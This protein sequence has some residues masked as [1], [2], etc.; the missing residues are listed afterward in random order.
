MCLVGEWE[1][2]GAERVGRELLAVVPHVAVDAVL[3]RVWADVRGLREAEIAEAVLARAQEVE[4]GPV[5]AGIAGTPVAAYASAMGAGSGHVIRVAVGQDR[6]Y[7]APLGLEVLEPDAKLAELLEGVGVER[8]GDLASLE[9]ESVE[10]RFGAES[11]LVWR[12]SRG[13]DARALFRAGSREQHQ[14]SLD[15]IDYVVTDPERLVF[16]ANAL[17]GGICESLRT[18]GLHARRLELT[19]PLA[20]GEV[21]RRTLTASRPTASRTAWLRLV[22]AVLERLTVAD[23]VAGVRIALLSSEAAASVQGDLFDAGFATASAVEAA[24]ARMIETHGPVIVRPETNA[25]PLVERRTSFVEVET[26]DCVLNEPSLEE[27]GQANQNLFAANSRASALDGLTLQILP[28]PRPV[29]VET[30]QRRDHAIPVRYHDVEWN[31]LTTV[32][33]P[34]RI[35]GGQWETPYARAYYRGLSSDGR[36]VWLYHDVQAETWY[37]HGW[38]D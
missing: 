29:L 27:R 19:L 22:R 14:A 4:S 35:S 36:L 2:R 8:C 30:M 33:G 17:L 34:D 15:F 25:H 12:R 32:A 3:R 26:N 28:E 16:T 31:V 11:L 1:E 21:W 18:R 6:E 37:L 24:L 9:R 20:N 23:A 38:W 13:D 5:R 10:V 7:L